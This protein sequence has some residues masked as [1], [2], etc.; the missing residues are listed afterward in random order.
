MSRA[1]IGHAREGV[2]EEHMARDLQREQLSSKPLEDLSFDELAEASGKSGFLKDMVRIPGPVYMIA[3]VITCV[4]IFMVDPKPAKGILLALAICILL[5]GW[6]SYLFKT[7][8][9]RKSS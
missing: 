7:G 2:H 5:A 4:F 1:G 3:V 9:Y 6:D 8:S